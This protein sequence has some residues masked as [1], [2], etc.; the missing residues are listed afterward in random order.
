M[1]IASYLE[2]SF[3]S[4]VGAGERGFGSKEVNFISEMGS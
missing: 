2:F 3:S 1:K 4:V